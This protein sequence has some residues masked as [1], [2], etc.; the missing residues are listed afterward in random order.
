M[1]FKITLLIVVIALFG[2]IGWTVNAQKQDS[3]KVTKPTWEYKVEYDPN[4]LKLN[5]LGAQGWEI[6]GV[7]SLEDANRA[8]IYFKKAR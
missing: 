2:V 4:E 3:F 5:E 6:I 7:R 1:K 8:V